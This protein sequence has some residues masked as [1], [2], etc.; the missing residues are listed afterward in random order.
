MKLSHA[1]RIPWLVKSVSVSHVD[2]QSH[3]ITPKIIPSPQSNDLHNITNTS[4]HQHTATQRHRHTKIPR[5][6]K[7]CNICASDGATLRVSPK[8]HE[9]KHG[10]QERACGQCWEAYLSL[11]V[12]EKNKFSEIECMFCKSE[13]SEAEL[14]SLARERTKNR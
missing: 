7:Y 9:P 8:N 6:M 3:P 2:I 11:Q 14:G 5:K 13:M 10:E 12:E 4:T 1:R